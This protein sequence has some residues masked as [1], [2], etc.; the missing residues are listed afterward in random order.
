MRLQRSGVIA[1]LAYL[2]VGLAWIW[3][4]QPPLYLIAWLFVVAVAGSYIPGEANQV[5][6]A[7]AYLAVPA[8]AYAIT[9]RFAL[10]A[11]VVAVAGLFKSASFRAIAFCT[12]VLAVFWDVWLVLAE[13]SGVVNVRPRPSRKSCRSAAASDP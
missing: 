12:T 9:G 3:I 4:T 11:V 2:V 8:L 5:S 1:G 7:R 10:L 6:L 13:S